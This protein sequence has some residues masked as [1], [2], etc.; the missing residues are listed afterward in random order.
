M[1]MIQL[2]NE[3][4]KSLLE[5]Y[6]RNGDEGCFAE[7]VRRHRETTIA[8]A[9]RITRNRHDAEDV[10]QACFTELAINPKVVRSSVPGWLRANAVHGALNL[11]RSERRRK[12]RENNVPAP[13]RG[14]PVEVD[15]AE[16]ATQALEKLVDELRRP[17]EMKFVEGL[18]QEEIA[19]RLGVNQS[20]VSRR[21]AR[22]IEQ[23]RGEFGGEVRAGRMVARTGG[24]RAME[25][26][27]IKCGGGD[28]GGREQVVGGAC[29]A[30]AI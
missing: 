1:S 10:A 27:E 22:A 20:T 2:S 29:V 9:M 8:A 30:I 12:H 19:R 18:E 23:L 11:T 4:D 3:T 7:L 21:L 25:C 17:L 15:S 16:L 5:R 14:E 28:R 26:L 6:E 24:V 13:E